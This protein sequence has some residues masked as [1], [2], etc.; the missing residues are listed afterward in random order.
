[1]PMR[2]AARPLTAVE[3]SPTRLPTRPPTSCARPAARPP[4]SP[5]RLPTRALTPCASSAARSPA[6]LIRGATRALTSCASSAA[7]SPA[8]LIRGATRAPTSCASSAARPPASPTRAP[9]SWAAS[10]TREDTSA[11]APA[12]RSETSAAA[13]PSVDDWPESD[14]AALRARQPIDGLPWVS[15][16]AMSRPP[17]RPTFLRKWICCCDRTSGSSSSQKRC[18]ASVV[19]TS[20]AASA[21]DASRGNLPNASIVPATILTPAS[22][23]TSVTSSGRE[24]S[25]AISTA[26]S[27]AG[28]T[29]SS[30]GFAACAWAWGDR[31]ALMP[32]ETKMAASMG[33]ATRRRIMSATYPGRVDD[34]RGHF[35]CPRRV[36]RDLDE[37]APTR[38]SPVGCEM[39]HSCSARSCA[40]SGT[41]TA[42]VWVETE[43]RQVE[44]LGSTA[45]TFT[46]RAALRARRGRGPEPG[47]PPPY[48]VALDG[49]RVWPR[50]AVP[51]EPHPH[52]GDHG[53]RTGRPS[54]SSSAPAATPR[55]RDADL[56]RDLGVDA[57]DAYAARTDPDRARPRSLA[58]SCRCCLLGDQVYADE[59]HAP[60]PGVGSPAARPPTPTARVT[61]SSTIAEYA[62]LYARLVGPRAALALLHRAD[63]AMIFDDHDIR[64]DWNT[65][66]A[67][68]DADGA[69][70]LVAASDPGR[71]GVVLGLPAPGQPRPRRRSRPTRCYRKV[72]R[73]DGDDVAAA[74]G[75]RRPRGRRPSG[76]RRACRWS[77]RWDLGRTRLLMIDSRCGRVSTTTS[78]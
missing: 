66:Q 2:P 3:A 68:R 35:G 53:D 6:T 52:P 22:T 7:R 33:R 15:D 45:R 77:Y 9:T 62:H 42:T 59:H 51:R 5:A 49:E 32:P 34:K 65:S 50:R 10:P 39:C 30:T 41:T 63:V 20:D 55:R 71:A 23:L 26:W 47:T 13:S 67:W 17:S 25:G 70:G 27:T 16:A 12:S 46:V 40:T 74:R 14:A 1:M 31:R 64:D 36:I 56:E 29:A 61:R 57:L 48:E 37:A 78:A 69:R 72:T 73:A 43:R 24:S 38:L 21:V 8:S 4:A 58:P 54:G 19:G 60:H 44:V 28:P 75:V 11:A 76:G 18:P